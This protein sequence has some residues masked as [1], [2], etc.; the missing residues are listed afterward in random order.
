MNTEVQSKSPDL[1][2][3]Q[4]DEI[5]EKKFYHRIGVAWSNRKGGTKVKLSAFPV[6]GEILLLPPRPREEQDGA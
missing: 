1:V 2:A 5:G 3:Y 4:V 6:D